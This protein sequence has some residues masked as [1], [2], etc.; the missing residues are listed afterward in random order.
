MEVFLDLHVD[1]RR[2]QLRGIH[3][4]IWPKRY[5]LSRSGWRGWVAAVK[6]DREAHYP[7]WPPD[8][9]PRVTVGQAAARSQM[10]P[11]HF[12]ATAA[13]QALADLVCLEIGERFASATDEAIDSL[14]HQH[15]RCRILHKCIQDPSTERH[16]LAK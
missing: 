1:F 7:G 15:H 5:T 16:T 11:F 9:S 3:W 14:Q 13:R 8:K 2:R 4:L 10:A 12:L 6:P